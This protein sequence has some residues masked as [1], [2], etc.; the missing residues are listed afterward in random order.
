MKSPKSKLGMAVGLEFV[1]TQHTRDKELLESL[2]G[3]LGCGRYSPSND[4][5]AGNYKVN[6][7]ADIGNKIIPFFNKYPLRGA[8]SAN[9]ADFCLAAEIIKV[10]G[11]LTKSGLE[12]IH[13]I[14]S[15]MNKGRPS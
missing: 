15:G 2:I 9:F 5:E 4:T 13:L 6:S 3:F 11:H 10:G 1:V 12:Q 14:K 7:I 8:K